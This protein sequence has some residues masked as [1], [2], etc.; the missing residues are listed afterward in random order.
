MR[1]GE[2]VK[3]LTGEI[4]RCDITF[5]A[6]TRKD[7]VQNII[8]VLGKL[9]YKPLE[10]P[11]WALLQ[12]FPGD[13]GVPGDPLLRNLFLVGHLRSP[14]MSPGESIEGQSPMGRPSI[15]LW[16]TPSATPFRTTDNK[17]VSGWPR[18]CTRGCTRH[19]PSTLSTNINFIAFPFTS[20]KIIICW[21]PKAPRVDRVVTGI[22]S[23][24]F[25]CWMAGGFNLMKTNKMT[26][27]PA[28]NKS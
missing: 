11:L 7:F 18:V 27:P 26:K 6:R 14:G 3:R 9:W 4:Q 19:L 8:L 23:F 16:V 21:G 24:L 20:D 2:K 12:G 17:P 25:F 10:T 22:S 13:P 15:T 28:I 1:E 5:P